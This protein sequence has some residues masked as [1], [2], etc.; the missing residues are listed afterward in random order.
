MNYKGS[1]EFKA[2][3][4]PSVINFIWNIIK[5]HRIAI[6]FISV[7]GIIDCFGNFAMGPIFVKQIIKAA[8][9]YTGARSE[10]LSALITP[11][12]ILLTVWLASDVLNRIASWWFN[13]KIEP[14]I[15]AKIKLTFLSRMMKNSYEFFIIRDKNVSFIFA[16]I[17]GSIFVLNHHEAI[18]FNTSEAS[19]TV[20]NMNIG[21]IK[22]ESI[23]LLAPVYSLAA[24]II[25]L[26]KIGPIAKFP[27]QS[28]IPATD[29]NKIAIR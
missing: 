10:I 28:I 4:K 19:H 11:I 1:K 23:S 20:N 22:A 12:F 24:F 21:V 5:G 17:V 7:A 15:D 8:S 2:N 9:E 3:E 6:L 27:K 13:T 14:T 18:R 16:S 26:T 29:I 25:C